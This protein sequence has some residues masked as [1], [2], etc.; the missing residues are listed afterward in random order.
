LLVASSLEQIET[1]RNTGQLNFDEI[2]NGTVSGSSF[3]GFPNT[4]L[5]VSTLPGPDFVFGTADDDQSGVVPNVTRQILITSLCP[6]GGTTCTNPTL[7]RIQV[8]L[9]YSANGG[10]TQQ[11]I[12]V[13]YLNDD[14]HGNYV[15]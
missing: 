3:T 14:A 15:P 1:L 7:K 2:S 10:T 5:P 13:S 4:F 8:T 11:L 12:G 6:G 9:K